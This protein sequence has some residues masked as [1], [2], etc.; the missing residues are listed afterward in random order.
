[1]GWDDNYKSYFT[2]SLRDRSEYSVK[3]KTDD[4]IK[5]CEVCK[6]TWETFW[7]NSSKKHKIQMGEGEIPSIGKTRK[8]C[9]DCASKKASELVKYQGVP[10]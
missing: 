8:N 7:C 6:D 9:P 5:Y 4:L 10:L 3:D 1:M 2:N